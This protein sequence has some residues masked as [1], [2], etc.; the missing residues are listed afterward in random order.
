MF[1]IAEMPVS[2]AIGLAVKM[3]L[4]LHARDGGTL[5]DDA[6]V[7]CRKWECGFDVTYVEMAIAEDLVR[8][9]PELAPLLAEALAVGR[10]ACYEDDEGG[11][12]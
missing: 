3:Y 10:A 11:A 2:G 9:V 12:A 8:F 1:E 4:A 7:Y 6:A 5:S